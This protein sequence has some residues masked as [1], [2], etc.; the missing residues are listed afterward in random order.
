MNST[1]QVLLFDE[2]TEKYTVKQIKADSRGRFPVGRI[3]ASCALG[4]STL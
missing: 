2:K 4:T 1:S 3:D